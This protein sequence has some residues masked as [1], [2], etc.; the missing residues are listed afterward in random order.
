MERVHWVGNLFLIACPFPSPFGA[1]RCSM[2]QKIS[3]CNALDGKYLTAKPKP[4]E[5]E[6]CPLLSI[7]QDVTEGWQEVS[8]NGRA[9][10]TSRRRQRGDGQRRVFSCEAHHWVLMG[11]TIPAT[12]FVRAETGVRSPENSG[13]APVAPASTVCGFFGADPY[14]QGCDLG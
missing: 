10:T 11:R 2:G 6:P 1:H 5:S 4:G 9:T 8:R 7:F 14:S 3:K 12:S 13:A